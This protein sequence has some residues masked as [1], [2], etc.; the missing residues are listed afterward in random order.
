[1]AQTGRKRP[2]PVVRSAKVTHVEH[3]SPRV[4]NIRFSSAELQNVEWLPGQKIKIR[5]GEIMRSYTPAHVDT[6]QGWM[7]VVFFLHGSGPASQ[8]AAQTKPGDDIQFVGPSKSVPAA[9]TPPDWVLFLGDETAIG[10]AKALLAPLPESVHVLGAIEVDE[11]DSHAIQ[12]YGLPLTAAIRSG[13]HGDA[14]LDWLRNTDFPDGEGMIWVSG[15][16]TSAK[17][18]KDALVERNPPNVQF[19]MKPYWSSKGHAHRKAMKL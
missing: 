14:L 3:L 9:E 6:S 11:S 4:R 8:W 7:D 17:A 18:I 16:A 13:S 12:D 5:V 10:L 19:Q 15:E 1:M 2:V